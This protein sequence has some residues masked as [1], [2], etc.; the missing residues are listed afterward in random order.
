[1]KLV[2]SFGGLDGKTIMLSNPLQIISLRL[3]KQR[4]RSRTS[5]AFNILGFL[6]NSSCKNNS[7][8]ELVGDGVSKQII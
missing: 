4:V 7:L 2:L 5:D 1:M 8:F 3:S 6:I